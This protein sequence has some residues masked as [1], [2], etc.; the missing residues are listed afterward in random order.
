M[1]TV[2]FPGVVPQRGITY[3]FLFDSGAD[4]GRGTEELGHTQSIKRLVHS[5]LR[6]PQKLS[7]RLPEKLVLSMLTRTYQRGLMR[8]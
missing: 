8:V 1:N 7:D 6:V 5:W 4:R 2:P 3:A